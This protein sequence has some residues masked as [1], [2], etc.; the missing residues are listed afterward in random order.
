[1]K[2]T[3]NTVSIAVVATLI[4]MI[5]AAIV[6][7]TVRWLNSTTGL[8]LSKLITTG[9]SIPGAIIAIGVLAMMVGLDRLLAPMYRSFGFGDAPLMLSMSLAM[10]VIAYVIRFMATGYN[11]VETGFEKVGAKFSESSRLL[12]LGITRTFFRVDLPLIWSS[13][14]SGIILTFVEI[15]KELP[16]ALLLRPFNFDTLATKAYQYASDE[17]I[18]SAA[19]PSLVIICVGMTSIILFHHLGKRV[20]Q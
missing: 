14:V 16:L 8:V 5:V 20:G 19:I 11:A 1:V 18:F 7:N 2:L 13:L 6:A 3:L 17:R 9:Y 12:G 10:L 4:I 15:V